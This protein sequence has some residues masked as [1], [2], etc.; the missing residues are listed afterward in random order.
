MTR[1]NVNNKTAYIARGNS[2]KMI[3]NSVKMPTT[4]ERTRVDILPTTTQKRNKVL[5]TV[6]TLEFVETLVDTAK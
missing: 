5:L 2:S 6:N 3:S 4:L 1:W